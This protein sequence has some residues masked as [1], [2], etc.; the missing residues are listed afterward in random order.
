MIREIAFEQFNKGKAII[1]DY[2]DELYQCYCINTKGELLF[3][4]PSNCYAHRIEDDNVIFVS[5]FSDKDSEAL[6]DTNG[7]QL[8]DFKYLTIFG[9]VEEGFFDVQDL[10][11]K[12]GHLSLTGVEVIPCIYDDGYYFSEGVAP[13]KLNDKWGVINHK[14]ETVIPF[15]Y[16]EISICS[17]N[18][19]PAKLNNKWGVIDKFNNTIIDFKFDD[20][21]FYLNHDCGSFP[22]K[23]DNKWGIADIYGN[24]LFDFMYDDCDSLDESGLYKFR[25]NDKWAIYS[26]EKNSF[27]SPFMYDDIDLFSNGL[28]QV[29]ING[30]SDCIDME[31]NPISDFKFDYVENYYKTNLVSVFN[32]RKWGLMN[33]GGRILIPIEYKDKIKRCFQKFVLWES[34]DFNQ[35]ITDINGNIVIPKKEHQNF[36]GDFSDGFISL[37]HYGYLNTKGEKLELKFEL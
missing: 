26:C 4:L 24:I 18:R 34:G 33:N 25:Q 8:T 31:N 19:I 3:K 32:D 10:N 9:G 17:N 15:M 6:F 21:E 12:R 20:I 37:Y 16:E 28:C 5:K 7:N 30:K 36:Y 11:R 14:N 29:K 2:K 13:M 23:L 35:Y 1:R 27:I 22:V